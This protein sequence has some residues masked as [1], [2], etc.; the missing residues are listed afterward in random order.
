MAII[1]DPALFSATLVASYL[2]GSLSTAIIVCRVMGLPDP[3][4][5]GSKNPGAT[6]VLRSGGKL[7]AALTL[8][9]DSLKGLLAVLA[10]RALSNDAAV[11]AAAAGG[12]FLG[13]LFPLYFRLRGGKGVAT[14]FG[15]VFGLSWIT[16][17]LALL[18]WVTMMLTFRVS[19]LSALISF[20]LVPLYFWLVEGQLLITVVL[21][22]LSLVLFWR[23]RDNLRR[24]LRGEESRVGSRG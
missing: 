11:L 14:A 2:L 1:S 6:N 13:H 18:T 19:S 17:A 12:A 7:A 9:G 10:A 24:L 21:G 22:I 8:L 5:T 3:R 23:H 4:T 15:A 20:A 16:G